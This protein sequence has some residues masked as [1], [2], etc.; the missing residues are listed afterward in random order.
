MKLL[1]GPPLP[2]WEEDDFSVIE[3]AIDSIF[4]RLRWI[5]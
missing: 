3:A 4:R 1:N 5:E 2:N